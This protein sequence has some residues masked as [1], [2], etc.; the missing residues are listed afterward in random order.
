MIYTIATF[1]DS[2]QVDETIELDVVASFDEEYGSS[3]PQ[4]PVE[5][6]YNIYD[7]IS[8]SNAK[9]S[10]TGVI[11]DSLFRR[12]EGLVQYVNGRFVNMYSADSGE[13]LDKK[14]DDIL[15]NMKHRLLQLRDGKEVFGIFESYRGKDEFFTS[16]VNLIYPCI[17]TNISFSN[18][19]G[20]NAIYPSMS[21]ERIRVATVSFE[22]VQNPTP[23]LIPLIRHGD[24]GN[25]TGSSGSIGS[26]SDTDPITAAKEMGSGAVPEGLKKEKSWAD[27]EV[28][29]IAKKQDLER[30]T[31][32]AK[33]VADNKLKNGELTIPQ[34]G[35]F[36]Q[37]T[38]ESEMTPKY[39]A[40]WNK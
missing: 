22:E 24:A 5:S 27:V 10:M 29:K 21:F 17:L 32:N 33:R 1:D 38:V 34:Y 39:G 23:K 9:F 8:H 36:V 20:G 31:L 16:Q 37:K 40:S 7:N 2:G 6:G 28:S 18:K 26:K 14:S 25:Q 11:T 12:K 35:G 15:Q 3:A 19:N 4:S 30:A 13:V